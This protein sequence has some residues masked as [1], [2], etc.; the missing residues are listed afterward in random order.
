[1]PPVGHTRPQLVDADTAGIL[2]AGH[3]QIPDASLPR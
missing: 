1:M 3:Q 2:R